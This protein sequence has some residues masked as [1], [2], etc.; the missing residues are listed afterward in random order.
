MRE[1]L[2]LFCRPAVRD[3][4]P[5]APE[6]PL[7]AKRAF[8]I[9]A[10]SLAS[11]FLEQ[12]YEVGGL[13]V[14]THGPHR[15]NRSSADARMQ[16]TPRL[17]MMTGT[18]AVRSILP[19]RLDQSLTSLAVTLARARRSHGRSLPG[20]WARLRLAVS[21]RS[22]VAL[23]RRIDAGGHIPG[24]SE[25]QGRQC[26]ALRPLGRL[27]HDGQDGASL[28]SATA[29]SSRGCATDTVTSRR[30][31][32]RSGTHPM[33]SFALSADCNCSINKDSPAA[34]RARM[35]ARRFRHP[36]LGQVRLNGTVSYSFTD[37]ADFPSARYF[38]AH[39]IQPSATAERTA[40][41][42]CVPEMGRLVA[43][44]VPQGPDHRR[45]NIRIGVLELRHEPI[46]CLGA[47]AG[48]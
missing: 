7:I 17:D 6:R 42:H 10:Q 15:L 27:D 21:A 12:H 36:L 20:R 19:R 1:A 14:P 38:S 23:A 3:G 5:L 48:R 33:P 13:F 16:R 43:A 31:A 29:N 2:S 35:A 4:T 44:D 11:C 46:D 26:V 24:T 40:T 47:P 34:P 22:T 9:S 18:P 39:R 25:F 30:E 8:S 45:G 41:G 37:S 32:R 28:R